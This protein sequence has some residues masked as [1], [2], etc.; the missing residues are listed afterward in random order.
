MGDREEKERRLEIGVSALTLLFLHFCK[1]M[2]ICIE[3]IAQPRQ[4]CRGIKSNEI[5]II[6][7]KDKK[8]ILK[9]DILSRSA[10]T[11]PES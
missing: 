2:Q 7:H 8:R 1:K 11:L 3:S 9:S 5:F 4:G 6:F 10:Q